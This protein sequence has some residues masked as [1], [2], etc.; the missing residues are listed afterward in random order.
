MAIP[1]THRVPP[2]CRPVWKA[3][4]EGSP[5]SAPHPNA[6]QTAAKTRGDP[7]AWGLCRVQARLCALIPSLLSFSLRASKGRRAPGPPGVVGPQV[8][9]PTPLQRQSIPDP[10]VGTSASLPPSPDPGPLTLL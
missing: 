3:P 5:G 4:K 6:A 2:P 10:G 8:R 1:G 7:G 9:P